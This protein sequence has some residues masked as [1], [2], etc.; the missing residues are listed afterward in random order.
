MSRLRAF[1]LGCAVSIV[2]CVANAVPAHAGDN[3]GISGYVV[4]AA[5]GHRVAGAP[6][7]VYR[8]PF[9]ENAVPVR[10]LRTDARGFFT[11]ITLAPGRYVVAAAGDAK[12]SACAIDDVY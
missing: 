8:Y 12:M 6:L 7:A 3:G 2:A 5:S 10:E 1:V 4:D 11:D 9:A